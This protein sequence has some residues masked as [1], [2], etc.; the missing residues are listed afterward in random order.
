M[1]TDRNS[2]PFVVAKCRFRR[3]MQRRMSSTNRYHVC[4]SIGPCGTAFIQA[5][6]LA[7]L[8]CVAIEYMA[9]IRQPLFHSID[10][11]E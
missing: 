11:N 3:G 10:L 9:A 1:V 2:D 4:A 6:I 8:V 5:N 7:S